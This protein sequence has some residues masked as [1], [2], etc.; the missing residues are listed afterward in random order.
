MIE[1]EQK[2]QLMYWQSSTELW[3][4]S[5]ILLI[6]NTLKTLNTL[7]GVSFWALKTNIPHTL[8]KMSLPSMAEA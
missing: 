7:E 4:K 3:K 8:E 6:G 1:S 2:R 5:I